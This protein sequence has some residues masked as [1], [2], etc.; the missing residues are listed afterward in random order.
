[1]SSTRTT[2]VTKRLKLK[3]VRG[4]RRV[5]WAEGT[6]DNEHMGKKKSKICCIFCSSNK[7]KD[8]NKYERP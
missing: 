4:R 5:T 6:I 1:M 3:L 7:N 2:T 8:V